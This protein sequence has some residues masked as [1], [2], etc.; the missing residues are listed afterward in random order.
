MMELWNFWQVPGQWQ[1][2]HQSPR[3][4]QKSRCKFCKSRGLSKRRV[5]L[6]RTCWVK[7]CHPSQ[8]EHRTKLSNA[9][10]SSQ[11]Q[12][13]ALPHRAQPTLWYDLYW[14]ITWRLWTWTNMTK[15]LFFLLLWKAVFL[16]TPNHKSWNYSQNSTVTRGQNSFSSENT[17]CSPETATEPAEVL[18]W[19]QL[20]ET[21]IYG[22]FH[23]VRHLSL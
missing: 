14:F 8:V 2:P 12:F 15:H 23:I 17:S 18:I 21:H 7:L 6:P 9:H 5:W 16:Q 22:Y 10:Q 1:D 19:R 4:T 20:C 11:G 3:I 13:N